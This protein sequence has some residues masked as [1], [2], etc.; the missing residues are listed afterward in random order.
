MIDK[1]FV[2]STEKLSFIQKPLWECPLCG[3]AKV[4]LY[5][6]TCMGSYFQR[7]KL[8]PSVIEMFCVIL[9]SAI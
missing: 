9:T 2:T 3:G 5:S 8:V 7:K 6:K 4:R 1:P